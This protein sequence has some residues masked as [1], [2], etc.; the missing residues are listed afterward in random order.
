MSAGRYDIIMEQGATFDLPLR[1][2]DS[3]GA[4]VDLSDYS[5]SMQVRESAQSSTV[6]VEFTSNL[7][8]NGFIFMSGPSEDREDS[9]NGNLRI[10]MTS[11][12]SAAVPALRGRYDLEL[13]DSTG[14]TIRLLEGQ[15]EVEA[16]ITR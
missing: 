4:A 7:S 9:A 5:A 1:Y 3:T 12:N 8:S 2:K 15:F 10:Y 16:E 13:T 14:Y 11:A 6:L